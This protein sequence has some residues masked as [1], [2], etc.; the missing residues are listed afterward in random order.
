MHRIVH[1]LLV[2]IASTGLVGVG[3][4]SLGAAAQEATTE[5]L[6]RH[7]II[8]AWQWTNDPNTPDAN[9]SYAIFHDDG[10]YIEYHPDLGVGIGVWR[11]TAERSLDLTIVFQDIDPSQAGFEPGWGSFWMAIAV[12]ASGNAMRAE[13]E[14]EARTPDGNVLVQLPYAGIGARL[15]VDTKT[16]LN[17]TSAGTPVP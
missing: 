7:P 10:T 9:I 3:R 14:L 12:D 2:V 17:P 8:G 1:L 16:P 4:G 5:D 6:A 11:P 15:T 13:G